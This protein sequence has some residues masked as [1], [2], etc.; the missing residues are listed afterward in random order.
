M[1]P[2]DVPRRP[3][4]S[5]GGRVTLRR[6]RLRRAPRRRLCLSF[7][8]GDL[9]LARISPGGQRGGSRCGATGVTPGTRPWLLLLR[10]QE[11]QPPKRQLGPGGRCLQAPGA[12]RPVHPQ[13]ESGRGAALEGGWP[14]IG[15]LPLFRP[16]GSPAPS[17]AHSRRSTNSSVGRRPPRPQAVTRGRKAQLARPGLDAAPSTS[18]PRLPGSQTSHNHLPPPLAASGSFL[19]CQIPSDNLEGTEEDG[20][21][22]PPPGPSPS[23]SPR[24]REEKTAKRQGPRT[25]STPALN[26]STLSTRPEHTHPEPAHP[27]HWLGQS[28][29]GGK[30]RGNHTEILRPRASRAAAGPGRMFTEGA[31]A[32]QPQS[33]M[34]GGRA[35]PRGR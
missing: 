29:V 8:I 19:G 20:P 24:G 13:P 16:P 35:G 18:G 12:A 31:G 34:D 22:T 7:S 30:N 10:H 3:P 28:L 27:G 23:F 6:R 26:P 4:V 21:Q 9:G 5:P 1:T 15:G 33:P 32:G 25:L 11:Q 2:T 14:R 17:L